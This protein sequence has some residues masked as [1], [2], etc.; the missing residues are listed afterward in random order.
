MEFTEATRAL[1]ARLAA[2]D[3]DLAAAGAVYLAV[4]AWKAV[5]GEDTSAWDR[6]GLEMLDVQARFYGDDQ[7]EVDATVPGGDR[8]QVRTAVADLIVHLARHHDRKANA[9]GNDL[10]RR[11]DHDAAAEQLRRAAA[12]LA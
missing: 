10:A 6:F 3:D 11:L 2:E 12:A 5:S 9:S 1:S 8:P 7:V 4:A